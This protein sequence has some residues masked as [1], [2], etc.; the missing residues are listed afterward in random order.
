LDVKKN[1]HIR[2]MNVY[3]ATN[4]LC[5][6]ACRNV[7]PLRP[8][9]FSRCFCTSQVPPQPNQSGISQRAKLSATVEERRKQSLPPPIEVRTKYKWDEKRWEQVE[10]EGIKTNL[11]VDAIKVEEGNVKKK[12]QIQELES[13]VGYKFPPGYVEFLSKYEDV[14]VRPPNHYWVQDEVMGSATESLQFDTE[15]DNCT[16]LDDIVAEQ[17]YVAEEVKEWSDI[18]AIVIAS[19]MDQH[20][21][22]ILEDYK[23][24]KYGMI[25]SVDMQQPTKPLLKI[26]NSFTEFL[27]NMLTDEEEE[28]YGILTMG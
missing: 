21:L 28:I 2:V 12:E 19:Q 11:M 22:L 7:I 17:S 4:V 25:C 1:N 10:L 23:D 26:A 5:I 20:I 13:N 18:P 8:T 16:T 27:C 24:F 6:P 15:G 14:V 9:R 3:R